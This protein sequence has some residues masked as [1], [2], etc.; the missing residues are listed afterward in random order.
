[1]AKTDTQ[2]Q[3]ELN[4]KLSDMRDEGL[5]AQ[6]K[7]SDI[8]NDGLNY[9]FG[10]QLRTVKFGKHDWEPIVCNYFFP[11]VMQEMALQSQRRVTIL[12]KPWEQGDA[13]GAKLWQRHMQWLFDKQLDLT[14]FLLK[15][16]FDG[17]IY[18]Q[19]TAYAYWEA[20]DTWD[21]EQYQWKGGPR[22]S[23]VPE[24]FVITDPHADTIETASYVATRRDVPVEWAKVRWPHAAE[25]IE[26]DSGEATEWNIQGDDSSGDFTYEG[27]VDKHHRGQLNRIVSALN[28]FGRDNAHSAQGHKANRYVTVEQFWFRDYEEGRYTESENISEQELLSQGRIVAD[29]TNPRIYRFPDT[30]EVVTRSAWPTRSSKTAKEPKYPCGRFVMRLGS[31]ILNPN[32]KDQ[33]WGYK[34]W[35]IVKGVNYLLPHS[36][37]GLNAVE[38]GRHI[39][40]WLNVTAAHLSTYVTYLASPVTLAEEGVFKGSDKPKHLPGAIWQLVKGGINRIRRDPAP[41]LSPGVMAIFQRLAQELQ[42]AIGSQ[43]ILRGRQGGNMTATEAL[44][45]ETNSRLRSALSNSLLDGFTV[46]LFGVLDEICHAHY[47]AGDILRVVGDENKST[48]AKMDQKHFSARYDLDIEVGTSLPFDEDRKKKEMLELTQ[49]LGPATYKELLDAYNIGN[50]DEILQRVQAWQ[51]IQQA[52]Q[53]QEQAAQSGNAEPQPST[54]QPNPQEPEMA[55]PGPPPQEAIPQ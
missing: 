27:A 18:G 48:L 38:M 35:P 7:W 39:Q 50:A 6:H 30:G 21:W 26:R 9:I 45:L 15:A 13:E 2:S 25:A 41:P 10:N 16:T 3:L 24:P 37:M 43:E 44:R 19:Y 11:A 14:N 1:M 52:V 53:Q 28:L 29:A 32:P 49:V 20:H 8:W 47:T 4:T 34:S 12:G 23:L 51:M 22:V 5:D 31:T 40:D 54:P 36:I 55:P 33:V 17:K 42:D 46:K